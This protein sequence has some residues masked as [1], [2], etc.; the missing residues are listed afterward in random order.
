ML[1][2]WIANGIYSA[3]TI[4]AMPSLFWQH[5]FPAAAGCTNCSGGSRP[6]YRLSQGPS[7][8][9]PDSGG[10]LLVQLTLPW[11]KTELPCSL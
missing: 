6:G 7:K 1:I 9:S 10:C 4:Y 3:R 2:L 8:S 11:P 5:S